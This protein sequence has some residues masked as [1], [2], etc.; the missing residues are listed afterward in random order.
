M[1]P[2]DFFFGMLDYLT[3]HD[4]DFDDPEWTQD[5]IV[6][7]VDNPAGKRLA[8]VRYKNSHHLYVLDMAGYLYKMKLTRED[9][10]ITWEQWKKEQ[11]KNSSLR[12]WI[13]N[14]KYA[15]IIRKKV[16]EAI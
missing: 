2:K 7:S 3:A 10:Y 11:K 1:T 12:L 4:I 9:V 8:F 15:L 14:E 5:T 13:D 6:C 16:A